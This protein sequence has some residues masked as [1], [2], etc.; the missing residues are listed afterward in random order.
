MI[1]TFQLRYGQK[2]LVPLYTFRTYVIM[3]Y[4]IRRLLK[5]FTG[6]KPDVGHLRIFGCTVYVHVPKEKR[7]KMDPSRKKGIFIGYGETSKAYH[8]YVPGQRQIE[9]SR[10]V[11]FD[12]DASFLRSRVSLGCGD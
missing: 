10:D 8:I 1:K 12:E 4:L 3:P 6:E 9:V 2:L 7:T 5:K 11:T